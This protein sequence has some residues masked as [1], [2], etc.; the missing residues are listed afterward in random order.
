MKKLIC[1]AFLALMCVFVLC[2]CGEENF[3]FTASAREFLY[4]GYVYYTDGAWTGFRSNINNPSG[5]PYIECQYHTG[6]PATEDFFV[7]W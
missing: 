1:I 2:S 7:Q 3:P 5:A 6:M 4:D